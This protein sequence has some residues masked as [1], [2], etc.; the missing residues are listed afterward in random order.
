MRTGEYE[1]E[2]STRTKIFITVFAIAL[3]ATMVL[4]SYEIVY[5][6]SNEHGNK[7]SDGTAIINKFKSGETIVCY[8][9][10]HVYSSEEYKQTVSKSGGWELVES[11]RSSQGY[12]FKKDIDD[13]LPSQCVS[14]GQPKI[15]N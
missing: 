4:L 7:A 1:P 9:K 12:V 8:S 11:D 5:P 3:A 6:D 2:W 10:A 13:Y 14:S 15:V